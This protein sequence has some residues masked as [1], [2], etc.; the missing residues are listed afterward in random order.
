MQDQDMGTV[1][2]P[3]INNLINFVHFLIGATSRISSNSTITAQRASELVAFRR[4]LFLKL[5]KQIT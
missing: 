3:L 5:I 1:A 4:G 2:F